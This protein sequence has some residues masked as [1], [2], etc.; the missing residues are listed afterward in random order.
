MGE[1]AWEDLRLGKLEG[2]E[3]RRRRCGCQPAHLGSRGG[4][5]PAGGRRLEAARQTA[6]IDEPEGGGDLGAGG[7]LADLD[8]DAAGG[9]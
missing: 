5:R 8:E 3:A 1:S 4:R 6:G 2:S 7:D 9:P